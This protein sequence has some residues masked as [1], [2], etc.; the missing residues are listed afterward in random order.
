LFCSLEKV[1]SPGYCI[2]YGR[3]GLVLILGVI[4]QPKAFLHKL[5][6]RGEEVLGD[7]NEIG[8]LVKGKIV[9]VVVRREKSGAP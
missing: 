9:T 2:I 5:K 1:L 6:T 7:E 4:P 3:V 8:E